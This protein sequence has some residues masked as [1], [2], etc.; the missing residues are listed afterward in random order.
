VIDHEG[1]I[2]VI[3]YAGGKVERCG[4]PHSPQLVR[5]HEMLPVKSL[6][7]GKITKMKQPESNSLTR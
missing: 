3:V 2:V 5:W 1:K 6:E 4:L 7:V